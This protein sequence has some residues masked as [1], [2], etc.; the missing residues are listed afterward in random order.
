M[1]FR[2]RRA[3][4]ALCFCATL[5]RADDGSEACFA[6]SQTPARTDCLVERLTGT[7]ADQLYQVE[8]WLPRDAQATLGVIERLEGRLTDE[9]PGKPRLEARLLDLRASALADLGRHAEAAETLASA[10]ALDD[11][12]LR[13]QWYGSSTETAWIA[14]LD[15]G[16]G[17]LQRAASSLIAAGRP[18]PA[19]ALLARAL[20]LG[21]GEEAERSWTAIGGGPVHGLDATPSYLDSSPWHE[22]LPEL[23]IPIIGGE[24]FHTADALGQVLLLDFWASWCQ[25]CVRELPFV[26]ALLQAESKRG[27]RVV[28]LNF[29]EEPDEAMGFAGSLG[30]QLPLGLATREIQQALEVTSV[31]TVILVDREGKIRGRWGGYEEGVEDELARAVRAM[32]DRDL[33]PRLQLAE[34]LRG[35]G[36]LRVSWMRQARRDIEGVAVLP[37]G[38]G[39]GRI[40]VARTR[41]VDLFDGEGRLERSLDG[42]Q[43]VGRLVIDVAGGPAVLSFRPGSTGVT[44]FRLDPLA[45]Q[46]WTAPAPLFDLE[47][48]APAGS[49]GRGLLLATLD[50]LYRQDDAGQQVVQVPGYR[51]V[52]GLARSCDGAE[53]RL[54]VLEAGR[55]LSWL[56]ESLAA[57]RSRELPDD[58]WT[59]VAGAPSEG[60]GVA[61][62]RALSAVTGRFL[63]GPASTQVALALDSGQLVLLDVASGEERFRARWDGISEVA[64]GDLDG[65]AYDELIVVSPRA[66]T[67]LTG[68]PEDDPDTK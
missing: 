4:L 64:A 50:G 8:T 54:I 45:L 12:T 3:A 23:A 32:L 28:A 63:P 41:S 16:V 10:I 46:G 26:D 33:E 55:R 68:A 5:A 48:L 27:L 65:D 61:S 15:A 29:G 13:L 30:L 39:R 40:A 19:R 59:L 25:P 35:G 42:E 60:V 21:A 56:D 9:G 2:L 22:R 6:R 31:P 18:D 67:V 20:A 44:L 37:A 14:P 7:T 24:T 17:R 47:P 51:E 1:D 58:S 38:P 49:G 43:A 57:L 62:S 34:V 66:V 36:A 52:S 53:C 11:G